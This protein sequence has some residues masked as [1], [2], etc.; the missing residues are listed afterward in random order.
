MQALGEKHTKKTHRSL[1][2]YFSMKLCGLKSR[3]W[4]LTIP[5]ATPLLGF[6]YF[7]LFY[8]IF[9]LVVFTRR[10]KL[11][12]CWKRSDQNGQPKK[13]SCCSSCLMPGTVQAIKK[14]TTTNCAERITPLDGT[15]NTECTASIK[16]YTAVPS[17]LLCA[18]PPLLALLPLLLLQLLTTSNFLNTTTTLTM[19]LTWTMMM[20]MMTI[21][22]M[23]QQQLAIILRTQPPSPLGLLFN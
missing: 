11:I 6:F 5:Q 22:T 9:S 1:I 10:W 13:M 7:I 14:Q 8:F 16:Y 15:I 19:T 18:V 3:W 20:M 12:T 2:D 21:F 4:L 17:L 23:Q